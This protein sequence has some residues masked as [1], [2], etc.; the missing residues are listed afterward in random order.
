MANKPVE[1]P[2]F[3]A[4]PADVLENIAIVFIKRVKIISEK[5]YGNKTASKLKYDTDII[6]DIITRIEKRRTYFHIYHN[7]TKMGEVNEIALV[8]FW[9]IKLM[10]FK[11]NNILNANLNIKL[12]YTLMIEILSFI[13]EKKGKKIIIENQQQRNLI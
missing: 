5:V 12:A 4:I 2:V 1:F 3:S 10:P 9:I 13:A 6:K 7:A 11:H 8:C